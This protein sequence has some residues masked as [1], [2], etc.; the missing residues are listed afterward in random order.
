MRHNHER[1][2]RQPS[3]ARQLD[4]FNQPK[5]GTKE[6]TPVWEALTVLGEIF[7][8]GTFTARDVVRTMKPEPANSDGVV[9][10]RADSITDALDELAGKRLD[11]P[12]A[13]SIGKLFQKCLVNRPTW[14]EDGRRTA[15]LLKSSGH[16]NNTYRI[17]V[18]AAGPSPDDRSDNTVLPADPD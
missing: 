1:H 2:R 3:A 4:L 18:S 11:R 17:K 7:K 14:I 5:S 12:T 15:R 6:R 13:L 16:S 10:A 8:D 9:K